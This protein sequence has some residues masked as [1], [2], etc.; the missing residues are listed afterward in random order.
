MTAWCRKRSEEREEGAPEL[1]GMSQRYLEAEAAILFGVDLA[2]F[3]GL[4][5]VRRCEMM[6]HLII[7]RQR[8]DYVQTRQHEWMRVQA[9]KGGGGRGESA[10]DKQMR[11]W[12]L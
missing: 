3:L 6:A 7:K 8:E 10:R 9:K 5:L 12:M 4:P 2:S 11:K 1:P